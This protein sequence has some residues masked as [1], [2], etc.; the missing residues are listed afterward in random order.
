MGHFNKQLP[1]NKIEA[2]FKELQKGGWLT[3]TP[4]GKISYK[5]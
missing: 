3:T 5:A 1:D 2:V 4:E